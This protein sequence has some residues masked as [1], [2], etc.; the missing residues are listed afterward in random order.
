MQLRPSQTDI[1]R[2]T[3]YLVRVLVEENEMGI[4]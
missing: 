3:G 4:P 1:F 2:V